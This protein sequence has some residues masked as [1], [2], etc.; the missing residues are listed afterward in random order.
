MDT[1]R[2]M[3]RIL[4]VDAV[5]G[6]AVVQP[7]IVLDELNRQLKPTGWTFRWTSPLR[8]TPRSAG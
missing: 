5:A 6:T 8:P 7:G 3:N 4:E 1:S 2:H